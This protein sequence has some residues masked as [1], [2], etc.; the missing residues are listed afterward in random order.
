M[1]VL[2]A[3][4]SDKDGII[5]EL[6][7]KRRDHNAGYSWFY[8]NVPLIVTP[9]RTPDEALRILKQEIAPTPDDR[10]QLISIAH[11]ADD[12]V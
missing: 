3:V 7:L 9:A 8:G 4:V 5:H 12:Q 11:S 6:V 2:R 10:I 1:S